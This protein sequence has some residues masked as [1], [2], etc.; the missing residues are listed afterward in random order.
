MRAWDFF[1]SPVAISGFVALFL[2]Q[3]L[4][5]PMYYLR[6]KEWDWSLLANAGGM[7][8]SHSALMTGITTAIGFYVG[9][10]TP[11]FALSL[12]IT[13][14]VVYDATGVRRQSGLQAAR[15]NM[16]VK[17]IIEER[18]WPGQEVESLLEIIGHSPGEAF[19]GIGFGLAVAAAVRLLMPPL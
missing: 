1:S 11:L 8:S 12:A 17:Q 10:G 4:K 18:R 7:P 9:W 14:I 13:S 2:A 19:A 5:V 3:I 6:K 15:I 16:I